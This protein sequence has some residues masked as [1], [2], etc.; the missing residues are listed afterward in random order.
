MIPYYQDP[1]REVTI[2]DEIVP[3]IAL[4]YYWRLP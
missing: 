4:H 1:N 3:G 2:R